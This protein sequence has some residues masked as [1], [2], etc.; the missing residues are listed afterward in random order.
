MHLPVENEV[1]L[2]DNLHTVFEQIVFITK[3]VGHCL[4]KVPDLITQSISTV[5]DF[6]SY[7]P[8]FIAFIILF[9]LGTGI[10]LKGTHWGS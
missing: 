7:C 4:S 3:N 10:I 2:F 8:P 5:S 9:M 6:C 1:S